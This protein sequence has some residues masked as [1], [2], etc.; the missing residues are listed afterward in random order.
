MVLSLAACGG[1]KDTSPSGTGNTTGNEAEKDPA[2]E[3]E[4]GENEPV[5]KGILTIDLENEDYLLSPAYYNGGMIPSTSPT[6]RRR[7]SP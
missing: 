5:E 3:G 4:Q 6:P 1:G 2:P 7:K